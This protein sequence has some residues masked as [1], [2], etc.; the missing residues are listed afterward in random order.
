[1]TE[2]E[3]EEGEADEGGRPAMSFEEYMKRRQDQ[4]SS[5]MASSRSSPKLSAS[6]TVKFSQPDD[7]SRS[8]PVASG[9]RISYST[10]GGYV[11]R[12]RAR[13]DEGSSDG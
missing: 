11:P 1:M 2:T 8:G 6:S 12:G 10:T 3:G 7:N 9:K 5:D 13:G 4:R